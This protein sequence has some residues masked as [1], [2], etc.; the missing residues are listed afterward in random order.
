MDDLIN[1]VS[2]K[3]NLP[4]PI[5]QAATSATL[6]YLISHCPPPLKN[7]IDV[8]LSNPTLSAGKQDILVAIRTLFPKQPSSA[9]AH[10]QPEG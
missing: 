2:D 3:S 1:F 9:K 5:A 8:I 6:D 4:Y 7:R 10:S